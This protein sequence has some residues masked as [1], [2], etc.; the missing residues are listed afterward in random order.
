V[1]YWKLLAGLHWE[2]AQEVVLKSP[3]SG[4]K[5]Y[6][7]RDENSIELDQSLGVYVEKM[8]LFVYEREIF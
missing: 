7:G 6:S 4:S 3:A 2:K 1:A 8:L 5:T